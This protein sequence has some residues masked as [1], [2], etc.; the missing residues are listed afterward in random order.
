[1]LRLATFSSTGLLGDA[2]RYFKDSF[3]LLAD[4]GDLFRV[5]QDSWLIFRCR[6][7]WISEVLED[8]FFVSSFVSSF[9]CLETKDSS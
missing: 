8:P 2:S 7:K 1:M 9:A 4:F 3:R 5:F 6:C